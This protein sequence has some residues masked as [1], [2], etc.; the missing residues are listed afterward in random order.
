M[1]S[2]NLDFDIYYQNYFTEYCIINF[3]Q[4]SW[5]FKKFLSNLF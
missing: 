3:N 5:F 2:N 4:C 1:Y